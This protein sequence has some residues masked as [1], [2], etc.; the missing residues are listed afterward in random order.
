MDVDNLTLPDS[1]D[2]PA[3]TRVALFK[4]FILHNSEVCDRCFGRIRRIGEVIE[5][6]GPVHTHEQN[7]YYERTEDAEQSFSPHDE[8]IDRYGSCYCLDCGSASGPDQLPDE[9]F[10]TSDLAPLAAN[11][12]TYI[13]THTDHSIDGRITGRA[14]MDLKAIPDNNGFDTEILAV[15]VARGIDPQT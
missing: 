11:I 5:R 15:A 14:I 12:V 4:R 6:Q 3:E 10:S 13:D 8:V 1:Y 9:T 2:D 7:A